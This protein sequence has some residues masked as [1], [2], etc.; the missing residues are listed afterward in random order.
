MRSKMQK[1]K[2]VTVGSLKEK[3]LVDAMAEYSKRLSRFCS[4]SVVELDEKNNLQ[5]ESKAILKECKGIVV[6]FAVEGIQLTS[7]QFAEKMKIYKDSGRE[8]TFV[9]GSSYGVAN[10][11]KEKANLLLS[12]SKMTLPHQL[13]R[14]F[15]TEQIYR[16][17]MINTGATY[18]K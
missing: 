6:V 18:H 16:A 11:V 9:I 17:F 7:E 8:V 1:I 12:L 3:Y 10:I 15:C 2:I 4:F 13:A 14:I 5:E